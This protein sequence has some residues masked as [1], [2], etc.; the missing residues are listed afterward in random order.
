[1]ETTGFKIEKNPASTDQIL[2]NRLEGRLVLENV[3]DF[4]QKMRKE[5][6]HT[7]VLDM[8]AISFLDSAGLG[9]LV[10]IFVS[11]RNQGKSFAL[12]GITKQGFAVIQVSG[13]QK[14]L[15]LFDNVEQAV[16]STSSDSAQ[17]SG[18]SR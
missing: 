3:N 9:A 1:M 2:I 7:L 15:P 18:T 4:L 16:A 5:A 11:R 12:A 13:L 17:S 6:A 8:S 10:S 14:L